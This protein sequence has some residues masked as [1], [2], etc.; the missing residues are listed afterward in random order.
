MHIHIKTTPEEVLRAKKWWNDLEVQWKFAYNET[1]FGVGPT[2]EPPHDDKL[3]M[4][5]LGADTFR[6]AGP[7]AHNPNMSTRLTNLS[8]LVPLYRMTY[9]SITNMAITSLWE[10]R[11]HTNLEHL[12]V[13]ENQLTS[14]K[15]IEGMKNLES[16]YF[17]HNHIPDLKPLKGL[18][19]LKTVYASNNKLK[20]FDGLQEHHADTIDMFYGLPNGDIRDR[21][22]IKFQNSIG[23]IVRTG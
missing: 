15:G 9:L 12:F 16:L 7:G 11:N 6:F 5:L 8:G 1:C 21:D 17:H 10:L 13:Y 22:V 14:L 23:L 4:M 19:K 18:K 3:M 2:M 20:N